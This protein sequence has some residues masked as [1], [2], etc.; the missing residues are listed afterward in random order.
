[1]IP[2]VHTQ[3]NVSKMVS[4]ISAHGSLLERQVM[5][6]PTHGTYHIL[7]D[8]SF[9]LHDGVNLPGL[10][11][12]D[13]KH[14]ISTHFPNIVLVRSRSLHRRLLCDRATPTRLQIWRR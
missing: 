14:T 6:G 4:R 10:V 7:N 11:K 5:L 9:L 8:R 12:W 3:T 1:M 2:V 13:L